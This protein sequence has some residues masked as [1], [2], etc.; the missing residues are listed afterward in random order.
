MEKVFAKIAD[1]MLA[2]SEMSVELN[3]AKSRAVDMEE[4]WRDAASLMIKREE[5]LVELKERYD[6]LDR[7]YNSL[8]EEYNSL[9]AQYAWLKSKHGE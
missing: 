4:A 9:R 1:L 8:K 7:N 2:V 6:I 3:D 5:E